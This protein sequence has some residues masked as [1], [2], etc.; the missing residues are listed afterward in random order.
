MLRFSLIDF[1]NLRTQNVVKANVLEMRDVAYGSK[2]N[3]VAVAQTEHGP[4]GAEHLLP[5]MWE[6]VRGRGGVDGNVFRGCEKAERENQHTMG[7]SSRD[8]SVSERRF[9]DENAHLRMARFESGLETACVQ[10]LAASRAD[11][12]DEDTPQG[13]YGC[14]AVP[15]AAGKLE[16]VLDLYASS[17]D[18]GLELTR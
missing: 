14:V 11:G 3:P 12:R 9:A 1:D 5:E 13:V 18:R 4:A 15:Q 2:V 10:R 7:V 16:E 17:E 8:F 6:R